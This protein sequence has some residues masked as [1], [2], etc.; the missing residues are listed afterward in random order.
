MDLWTW[1]WHDAPWTHGLEHSG[2]SP[3]RSPHGTPGSWCSPRRGEKGEETTGVLTRA[4]MGGGA[5]WCGRATTKNTSRSLVH[6]VR[7]FGARRDG[8][9]GTNVKRWQ[10]ARGG[11]PYIGSG[12]ASWGGRGGETVVASGFRLKLRLLEGEVTKRPID[13]G[14]WGG[15]S[16][17]STSWRWR[18]AREGSWRG[19][20]MGKRRW[21]WCDG[22][23]GMTLWWASAGPDGFM[24]QN[25]AGRKYRKWDGLAGPQRR[26]GPNWLG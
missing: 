4:W 15:G 18:G 25:G 2:G 19:G 11:A 12:V 22:R 8:E 24:D 21:R 5:A 26:F 23:M 3:E 16:V 13:E 10:N 17:G 9:N 20:A 6:G 14:K 7:G 1:R